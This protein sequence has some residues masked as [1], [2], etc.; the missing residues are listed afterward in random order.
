[1]VLGLFGSIFI[2]ITLVASYSE[3]NESVISNSPPVLFELGSSSLNLMCLMILGTK[4]GHQNF[5]PNP[6]S[7]SPLI[8]DY[9]DGRT[10]RQMDGQILQ[11]L[12]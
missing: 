10:D 2:Q 8:C 6:T 3:L 12:R 1:M 9:T 11:R 7:G 4:L 5:H